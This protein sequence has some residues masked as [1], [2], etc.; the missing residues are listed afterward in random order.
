L[1]YKI[2]N[3]LEKNAGDSEREKGLDIADYLIDL[4]EAV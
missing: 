4:I 1:T 2:S 3:L